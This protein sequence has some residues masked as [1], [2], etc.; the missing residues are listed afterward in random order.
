MTILFKIDGIT[1][2]TGNYYPVTIDLI[3]NILFY[4]RC[5]SLPV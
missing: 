2:A 3:E 4:K 5:L 1:M